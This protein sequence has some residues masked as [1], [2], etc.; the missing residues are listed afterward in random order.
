LSN[1]LHCAAKPASSS[2]QNLALA[3]HLTAGPS[4]PVFFS[5]PE[6]ELAKPTVS[7]APLLAIV[8]RRQGLDAR[9]S[10]LNRTAS[11]GR[12]DRIRAAR[13]SASARAAL[14]FRC[15]LTIRKAVMKIEIKLKKPRNPLVAP[16]RQR[17]AGAHRPTAGGERQRSRRETR[18]A[19]HQLAT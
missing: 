14:H 10:I 2:R 12:F 19:V 17:R 11:T 7:S 16:C 9:R 5:R 13:G 8:E 18:S 15:C 6:C 4:V 1:E 3:G